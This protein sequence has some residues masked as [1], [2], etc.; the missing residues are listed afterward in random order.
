[1]CVVQQGAD[2]MTPLNEEWARVHIDAMTRTDTTMEEK[3]FDNQVAQI[4]AADVPCPDA[5][6]KS[7]VSDMEKRDPLSM[8]KER[9]SKTYRIAA[10]LAAASIL[11]V[12]S[13]A[14]TAYL[15]GLTSPSP[16]ARERAALQ[17]PTFSFPV[18]HTNA[19]ADDTE[20]DLPSEQ[21]PNAST[22]KRRL[23]VL[24][25][26]LAQ[27]QEE[28]DTAVTERDE[29]KAHVKELEKSLTLARSEADTLRSDLTVARRDATNE[30]DGIRQTAARLNI[31]FDT[32]VADPS[33]SSLQNE[34][35]LYRFSPTS[36]VS[37][38]NEEKNASLSL[39]KSN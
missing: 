10:I 19:E 34:S 13:S 31:Q 20:S 30:P 22:L 18:S 2:S 6:W 23:V 25:N 21:E 7:L 16:A 32:N 4:L 14:I 11:M 33:S 37:D 3:R 36:E 27:V 35:A 15:I 9:A 28:R 5:L 24:K 38:T 17:N 12:F 1:M 29:I 39:D 8:R 26:E